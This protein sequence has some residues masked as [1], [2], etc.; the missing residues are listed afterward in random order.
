M[1]D[2]VPELRLRPHHL[3][4]LQ[5][6]VGHGYNEEF[7][8]QMTAVKKKLTNSPNTPIKIEYGAD[9]LCLHC[10]N[11]QNGHCMS[12]KPDIFD[13]S[14]LSKLASPAATRTGSGSAYGR[15]DFQIV[16]GIIFGIPNSLTLSH[17][18]I[19]ECCHG[20]EWKDLCHK[21]IGEL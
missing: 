9:M 4:C 12:D 7:V 20:C 18:M 15:T 8:R 11:C 16:P 21:V 14:V 6:F 19:E 13:Q 1:N 3:L 10:P 5:S 2:R 17:S